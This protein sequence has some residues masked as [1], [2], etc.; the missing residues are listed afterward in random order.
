MKIFYKLNGMITTTF[1]LWDELN[2]DPEN[3]DLSRGKRCGGEVYRIEEG[4]VFAGKKNAV[5]FGT[6]FD[7]LLIPQV[8]LL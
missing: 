3:R 1:P 2:F 4:R 6:A 5:P 7:F 8:I